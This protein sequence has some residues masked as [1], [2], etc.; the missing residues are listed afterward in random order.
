MTD[1]TKKSCWIKIFYFFFQ[2]CFATQWAVDSSYYSCLWNRKRVW[3]AKV[4]YVHTRQ[5]KPSFQLKVAFSLTGSTFLASLPE[6]SLYS[7]GPRGWCEEKSLTSLRE[8]VKKSIEIWWDLRAEFL[9]IGRGERIYY[10]INGN[11][12]WRTSKVWKRRVSWNDEAKGVGW[13]HQNIYI[14]I[15]WGD[16]RQLSRKDKCDP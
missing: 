9:K 16:R 1:T 7:L 13:F 12:F 4:T 10:K 3:G 2:L 5:M 14:E 8:W 11:G 6:Q 15:T